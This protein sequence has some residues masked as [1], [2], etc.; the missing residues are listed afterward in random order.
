MDNHQHQ[1]Q[2]SSR[3]KNVVLGIAAIGILAIVITLSYYAIKKIQNHQFANND[4][5]QEVFEASPEDASQL[6][7]FC[8]QSA[9]KIY[10]MKDVNAAVAEYKANIENCAEVYF[11]IDDHAEPGRFRRE[12]MYG[13]FVI[14]LAH[15][16]AETD[17]KAA[18]DLLSYA[19]SLKDWDFYLGPVS[20]DAQHVIEAYQESLNS[21]EEKVCIKKDE[22]KQKLIPV[23]QS[24]NFSVLAKTLPSNEVVWLGQPESDVGCPEK[25][26]SIVSILQKHLPGNIKVEESKMEM[27]ESED[28]F[29]SVRQGDEEKIIFVFRPNNDCLEIQ[30]VLVPTIETA[31]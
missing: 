4:T 3:K 21:S 13:D 9:K 20:C 2:E 18:N 17:R 26:S 22:F 8:T 19:K 11:A 16:L 25:L 30:S 28:L 24:K 14:D 23:L 29:L 15:F 7:G 10:A 31:E 27:N 6:Q 12:G 5:S 1:E